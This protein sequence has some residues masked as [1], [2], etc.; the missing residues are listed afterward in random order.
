MLRISEKPF[1]YSEN[2]SI[3]ASNFPDVLT[4][5]NRMA[6]DYCVPGSNFSLKS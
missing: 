2:M 4:S 5:F 6:V 1:E 3:I